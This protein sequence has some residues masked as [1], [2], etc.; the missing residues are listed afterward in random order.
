MKNQAPHTPQNQTP[1]FTKGGT[2]LAMKPPIISPEI[3]ERFKK[4]TEKPFSKETI[5]AVKKAQ[6]E[7]REQEELKQ[8]QLPDYTEVA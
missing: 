2:T 5:E 1:S 7:K 3:Y 4:L 8:N 6:R